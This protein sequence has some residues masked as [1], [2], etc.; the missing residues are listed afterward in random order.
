M[1]SCIWNHWVDAS[2][3]EVVYQPSCQTW[4]LWNLFNKVLKNCC[5]Y[6]NLSTDIKSSSTENMERLWNV[7]HLVV[8]SVARFGFLFCFNLITSITIFILWT[9]YIFI[10]I[11]Q[12]RGYSV[13][14][15]YCMHK[16]IKI[17]HICS[18]LVFLYYQNKMGKEMFIVVKKVSNILKLQVY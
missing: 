14:F 17:H 9:S 8:V 11:L 15:I 13:E 18:T 12:R 3:L 5:I 10:L 7:L 1:E 2:A 16:K 6:L 4:L